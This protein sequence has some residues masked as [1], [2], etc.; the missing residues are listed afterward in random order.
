MAVLFSDL[1]PED[2]S[3][4]A[5]ELDKQK[6]PYAIG[7][8]GS[9]LLVDKAQVHATRLKL[10]ARELPLHG[11]VGFELFNQSDLGM[12]EFMQKVNWQRALQGELTRTIAAFPQVRRV[13]V[14]L[15]IPEHGLFRQ[16]TQTAK[17]VVTLALRERG[18]L[19]PQQVQG[20]QRL[21]AAAVPGLAPGEVTVVDERGV[22]LTRTAA[23][24]ASGNW[25]LDLK[26]D[27][28]TYLARKAA[29]VLD[30]AVGPGQ[31]IASVDVTLDVDQVR[32]TTEDVLGVTDPNGGATAGVLVRER[33]S[34]REGSA[35]AR[36]PESR[37][38][39]GG[40]TQRDAEYQ[41][42]RRVEHVVSQPGSI[43]HVQV[44]AIVKTGLDAAQR[45]QLTALLG[46]AVGALGE[47]G[48]SVVLHAFDAK[49]AAV[50]PLPVAAPAGPETAAGALPPDWR[51]LA[52]G[53][54]TA[55]LLLVALVHRVS[56]REAPLTHPQRQLAL[57]QVRAWLDVDE[58][59]AGKWAP[60]LK[61]GTRD[62]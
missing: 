2:A 57:G 59:Q 41:A 37:P 7:A 25:Q 52:L 8:G 35:D 31:A 11:A 4:I 55:T 36:P 18:A 58:P 43:R 20:I 32:R 33:E 5:A 22:A 60:P 53:A 19:E 21:V 9:A 46:A 29:A 27:I 47:R 48:D 44:V 42:G 3:V 14:H 62:A 50:Q 17:A 45:A 28:E 61:E 38:A 39:R 6:V 23:Q 26:R 15:A 13:R 54:A 40:S 49:P 34:V 24:D 16:Q 56:R 12:T 51:W 1:A 30:G 10:M